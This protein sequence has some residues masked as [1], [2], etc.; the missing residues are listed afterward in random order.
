MRLQRQ[1][2]PLQL[3]LNGRDLRL[4]LAFRHHGQ[5]FSGNCARQ[6]VAHKGRAMHKAASG[7]AADGVSHLARG[8]RGGERHRPAGQRFTE[9]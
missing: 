8:Q 2:L 3:L 7:A 5:A 1:Q 6:R 4:P 9:A